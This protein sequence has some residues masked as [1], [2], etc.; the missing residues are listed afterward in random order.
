[1]ADTPHDFKLQGMGRKVY[2]C[3]TVR[4]GPAEAS[5]AAVARSFPN[6]QLSLD[7]LTLALAVRICS[8]AR[9]S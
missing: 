1:M 6:P 7:V 2:V 5:S 4:D 9:C 8:I 3:M